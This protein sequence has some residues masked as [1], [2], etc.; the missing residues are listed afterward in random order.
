MDAGAVHVADPL[1][2]RADRHGARARARKVL[3]ERWLCRAQR[4]G[5]EQSGLA[6]E[7]P[8]SDQ[9]VA[10]LREHPSGRSSRASP[11]GQPQHP[12]GELEPA[13][14]P[15]AAPE[16]RE[17]RE[18]VR[19]DQ[20]AAEL[21]AA[22][23]K[24]HRGR[25]DPSGHGRLRVVPHAQTGRKEDR[26]AEPASTTSSS[27]TGR[28]RTTSTSGAREWTSPRASQGDRA[29]PGRSR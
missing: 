9:P 14:R 15:R 13:D 11:G 23:P 25:Q 10:H 5:A 1:G 7:V 22:L 18:A 28:R 24:L 2:R 8:R 12:P 3:P 21:H 6:R 4:L 26:R 19:G 17:V 29:S 27:A 20:H 16:A